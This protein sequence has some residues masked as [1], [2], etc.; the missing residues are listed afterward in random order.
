VRAL[1]FPGFVRLPCTGEGCDVLAI[2][3]MTTIPAEALCHGCIVKRKREKT[4]ETETTED[5]KTAS[6]G[7]TEE[8]PKRARKGRAST[9]P[10]DGAHEAATATTQELADRITEA[11]QTLLARRTATAKELEQI[12]SLIASTGGG[13]PASA[14]ATRSPRPA[15][16]Q[17]SATLARKPRGRLAR[18]SPEDIAAG[19]AK[20]VALLRKHKTGLRAE[21]IRME[22]G[23]VAKEMPMLLKSALADKAVKCTGERRATTYFTK[24]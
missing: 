15:R 6:N 23:M 21:Q 17:A 4:M 1:S 11:R 20:I 19:T 22:L 3:T 12:D 2:V 9:A 18:R 13:S 24:A 5:T 8:A 10:D 7:V 16:K 14:P